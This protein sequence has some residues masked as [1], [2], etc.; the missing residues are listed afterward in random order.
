MKDKQNIKIENGSQ[1][2]VVVDIFRCTPID[3]YGKFI[4][5]SRLKGKPFNEFTSVYIRSETPENLER[6]ERVARYRLGLKG[7]KGRFRVH[8]SPY[9]PLGNIIV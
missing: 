1:S 2:A 7:F 4:M 8:I 9:R 6:I 3:A 5:P